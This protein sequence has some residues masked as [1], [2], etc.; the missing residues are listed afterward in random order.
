MEIEFEST[1]EAFRDLIGE[2]DKTVGIGGLGGLDGEVWMRPGKGSCFHL[3]VE[4]KLGVT[5]VD[6][7]GSGLYFSRASPKVGSGAG[8]SSIVISM[9]HMKPRG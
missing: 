5:R 7:E 3:I 4:R 9:Y 2:G 1:D 6:K 8:V